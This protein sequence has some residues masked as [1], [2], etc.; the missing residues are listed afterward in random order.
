MRKYLF[1]IVLELTGIGAIGIGIGI[2]I[3]LGADIGFTMIT[4]GSLFVATGGIIW[5]KF[6]KSGKY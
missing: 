4:V 5:G 3:S 1:P 6:V 2:E